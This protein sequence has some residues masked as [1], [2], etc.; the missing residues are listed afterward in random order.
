MGNLPV[1]LFKLLTLQ[2]IVCYTIVFR[3]VIGEAFTKLK[4]KLLCSEVCAAHK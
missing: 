2:A 1:L 4:V 3:V